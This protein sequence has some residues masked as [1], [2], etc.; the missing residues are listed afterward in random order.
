MRAKRPNGRAETPR[1]NRTKILIL[2]AAEA[3]FANH[4]YDAVSMR[5]I[6]H[7]AGTR[8]ALVTYHFGTKSALF[9][10]I[11]KRRAGVLDR[12]RRE[13]L[14]ALLQSSAIDIESLLRAFMEPYFTMM[15]GGQPGWNNY[16]HLIARANHTDR[17]LPIAK[18]YFDETALRYIDVL[19]RLYPKVGHEVLARAF[20]FSIALMTH[21]F[22][23]NR[24]IERLSGGKIRADDLDSA[25]YALVAYA[26]GGIRALAQGSPAHEG[27]QPVRG[28]VSDAAG[29]RPRKRAARQERTPSIL[30]LD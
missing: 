5:D 17:W 30:S 2:D 1:G 12:G 23:Q 24:R 11:I 26:A 19:H 8:L 18:R 15:K 13:G 29:K 16:A 4:D 3:Q 14:D 10:E 25:Y 9:E 7:Q 27:K 22:A 21:T 20:F 6:V 28:A